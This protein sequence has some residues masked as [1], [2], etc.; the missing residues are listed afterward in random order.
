MRRVIFDEDA[1]RELIAQ[2]D[3]LIQHDAVSAAYKLEAYVRW[4]IVE[5]LAVHPTIGTTLE[6]RD[7]W[8][9]CIPKSR[10]VLWYRFTDVE[11]KI[12]YLWHTSE[13]RQA[14]E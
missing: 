4:F 7:L 9:F 13:D 5:H 6:H 14:M 2:I 1:E 12:V 3:Y 10:L 11:L 8:E